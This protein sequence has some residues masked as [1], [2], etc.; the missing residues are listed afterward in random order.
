MGNINMNILKVNMKDR[1][2]SNSSTA[3]YTEFYI[4]LDIC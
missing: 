4:K 2:K 3:E 1:V